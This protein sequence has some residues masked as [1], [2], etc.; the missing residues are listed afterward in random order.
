MDDYISKP[1]EPQKLFDTIDRWAKLPMIENKGAISGF[2]GERVE[3]AS[4]GET[5]LESEVPDADV[6]LDDSII[7]DWAD[8]LDFSVVDAATDYD[9]RGEEG[10]EKSVGYTVDVTE[11]PLDLDNALPRFYN[12]QEFFIEML[13]EFTEHLEGRIKDLNRALEAGDARTM[14][15][16]AHNLKGAASNFNAVRL[17]ALAKELEREV[18]LGDLSNAMAVITGIDAEVPRLHD[19]LRRLKSKHRSK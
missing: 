17:T 8:R 2:P 13:D 4:V 10:D 9:E 12:D 3:D 1:I 19:Y 6:V 11:A 16:L 15:R 7:S 5:T 14:Q 18:A